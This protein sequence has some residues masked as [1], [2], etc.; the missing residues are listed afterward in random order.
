MNPGAAASMIKP[1][2][3]PMGAPMAGPAPTPMNR[4]VQNS[5]ARMYD[6]MFNKR[7]SAMK[8]QQYLED[9][10]RIRQQT[11]EDDVRDRNRDIE[12]QD[13]RRIEALDDEQR[14][15]D[16]DEWKRDF[17][18]EK[19][20]QYFRT[21][22]E[23]R[24]R[25]NEKKAQEKSDMLIRTQEA[26]GKLLDMAEGSRSAEEIRK[27]LQQQKEFYAKQRA[28]NK[29]EMISKILVDVGLVMSAG[30]D[31]EGEKQVNTIV[32]KYIGKGAT[33][34]DTQDK[35]A[36]QSKVANELALMGHNG[37]LTSELSSK[38]KI[39]LDDHAALQKQYNE[40][41]TKYDEML[42]RI[43]TKKVSDDAVAGLKAA[44]EE[45]IKEL[46]GSVEGFKGSSADESEMIEDPAGET[47]KGENANGEGKGKEGNG[48][49]TEQELE[50]GETQKQINNVQAKI[51]ELE[52]PDSITGSVIQGGADM[53]KSGSEAF[54]NA[55]G[56]KG[57]AETAMDNAGTTAATVYGAYKAG[58][59]SLKGVEGLK[60]SIR[61]EKIFDQVKE[62]D[63]YKRDTN[64]FLADNGLK[65]YQEMPKPG[66]DKTKNLK[67]WIEWKD[68]FNKH[69]DAEIGAKR[70]KFV[71]L[72]RKTLKGAA[73]SKVLRTLGIIGA[74]AEG[75]NL[76]KDALQAT[77]VY[78]PDEL[79]EAHEE[80]R[81]LNELQRIEAENDKAIGEMMIKMSRD[82]GEEAP[83]EQSV[84]DAFSQPIQ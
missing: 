78:I 67:D 64:K 23:T 61:V 45:R 84:G 48:F 79:R 60:E 46:G 74:V 4:G 40:S 15:Y 18:K 59:A 69:L 7:D 17:E 76:T 63:F 80:L 72:A 28:S 2:A 30:D 8:R 50:L 77:G 62:S 12:D 54:E 43:S 32:E 24:R 42:S 10:A 36:I 75:I 21:L 31:T 25:F 20:K 27:G 26:Y 44:Y 13:R 35:P 51:D 55:G 73:G 65:T 5:G 22:R 37:L 19:N 1:A 38:L 52:E 53:I 9:Q 58:E 83:A 57:L 81:R 70:S 39:H 11:L 66:T 68:G 82:D 6:R 47:P 33:W 34:A 56:V 14:L 71:S 3:I 16:R 29:A 49:F 41:I